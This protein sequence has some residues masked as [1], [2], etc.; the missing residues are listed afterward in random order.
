MWSRP[1]SLALFYRIGKR[2]PGR[3]NLLARKAFH[4]LTA[5]ATA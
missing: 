5:I 1:T 3:H 4:L 2:F